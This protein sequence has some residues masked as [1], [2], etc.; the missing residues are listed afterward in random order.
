MLDINLF[1]PISF[2]NKYL[3]DKY[4][5]EYP[6]E[7]SEYSPVTILSW[8]HYSPCSIAEYKNHIFLMLEYNGEKSIHFPIGEFNETLIEELIDFSRK[9]GATINIFDEDTMNHFHELHPELSISEVRGYFEYCYT[10]DTLSNLA[11]KKYLKIRSQLNKFKKNYQYQIEVITNSNRA[12]ALSMIKQWIKEKTSGDPLLISEE[13]KAIQISFNHWEDL[14]LEGI[15]IR[16][17]DGTVIAISIWERSIT[18]TVLIHYEK[19]LSEYPGIYKIINNETALRLRT[20]Y[21]WINR[22]GDMDEPG[23]REAKQRYH[24]GRFVKAYTV[25]TSL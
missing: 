23:L 12:D 7:H 11:G 10:S 17:L 19:G 6:Q 20:R 1:S 3:L 21:T 24:P 4:L 25:N 18:N 2:D 15:L 8:E 13:L 14:K 9:I 16:L 5:A 22:E